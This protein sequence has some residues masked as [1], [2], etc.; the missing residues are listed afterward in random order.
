MLGGRVVLVTGA[1]RPLG[2]G[3]AD[4]LRAAGATV[5][6]VAGDLADREGALAAVAD[7]VRE[8]GRPHA[9]VHAWFAEEGLEPMPLV[10]VDDDRWWSVWETTMRT[11]LWLCQAVHPHLAG[12]DGRVVFLTP[13]LSMSGAEG[14]VAL[15]TAVEAQRLLAKA[16]ARQWGVDGITVNCVAPSPSVLGL[17]V[18]EM[19][20]AAP[21][22]GRAGDPEDDLGPIVAF[23]CGAGSHFLTGATLCADG[24]LWMAP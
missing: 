18:G 9:L 15:A 7:A 13:T 24:G 2:A 6:L 8:V 1:D 4:G 22:L 10:D 5:G 14:L 3:L 12:N 11:S 17:D 16:T 21:A 19:A 23:L 20:L